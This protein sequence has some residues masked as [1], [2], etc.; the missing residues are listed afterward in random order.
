MTHEELNQIELDNDEGRTT[1]VSKSDVLVKP[2]RKKAEQAY[3]DIIKL[4]RDNA[5]VLQAAGG[6]VTIVHPMTQDEHGLSAIC[7]YMAG[8]SNFPKQGEFICRTCGL[9]K[10]PSAAEDNK[11]DF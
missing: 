3:E 6:V 10:T 4:A 2:D 9:R 7:L 11:Y 5:L 1:E 8:I